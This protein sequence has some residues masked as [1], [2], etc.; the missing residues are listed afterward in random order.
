MELF[1]NT[2]SIPCDMVNKATF[3]SNYTT[4]FIND[5]IMTFVSSG[6]F[7]IHN[8]NLIL[9]DNLPNN[10][11][12]NMIELFFSNSDYAEVCKQQRTEEFAHS[13][14]D[15]TNTNINK[16][17]KITCMTK[18]DL[19]KKVK[20]NI[21]VFELD[22]NIFDKSLDFLIKGEYIVLNNNDMYE[23]IFY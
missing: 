2:N 12:T 13:R 11:T 20:D 9:N 4:K 22:Q 23:K 18:D 3:L 17:L 6:L 10:I 7:K 5:I 8:N 16:I 1:E 15:I 21:T 14:V 19:F